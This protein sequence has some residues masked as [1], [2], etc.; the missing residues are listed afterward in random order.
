VLF[1]RCLAYV[2]GDVYPQRWFLSSTDIRRENLMDWIFW[3]IFY[4]DV[5][6]AAPEWFDE[7]RGYVAAIEAALGH[8][9]EEGRN[10]DVRSMRPT[11][12]PV[13]MLHRPLI[14]YGVSV[15]SF[16]ILRGVDDEL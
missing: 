15:F 14:W 6:H 4:T 5:A 3:A 1:E 9:L 7:A 2:S 10:G 11:L 16:L 12:D 13:V 8:Q